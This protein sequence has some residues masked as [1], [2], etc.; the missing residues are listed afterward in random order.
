MI[1]LCAL[2]LVGFWVLTVFVSGFAVLWPFIFIA[3]GIYGIVEWLKK[4]K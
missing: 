3:L 1:L 2:A 4:D